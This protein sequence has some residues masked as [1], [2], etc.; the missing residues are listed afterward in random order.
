MPT[1]TLLVAG[2]DGKPVWGAVAS[3]GRMGNPPRTDAEGKLLW[4]WGPPRA[5]VPTPTVEVTVRAKGFAPAT[6]TLF[7]PGSGTETVTVALSK[8]QRLA[9]RVLQADGTPAVGVSVNVGNGSLPV[10]EVFPDAGQTW[11]I[12]YDD[13]E[14]SRGKIYAVASTGDDGTFSVEDLPDGPYHVAAAKAKR[15][16]SGGA[17][18]LRAVASAVPAGTSD[19]SLTLPVDD[20]PPTGRVEGRLVDAKT[21][22]PVANA[23]VGLQRGKETLAA[24]F[25]DPRMSLP[26][27]GGARIESDG[28][29]AFEDVPVG[30]CT[31][32]AGAAGYLTATGAALDVRVGQ[33]T[34]VPPIRLGV[35]ASIL[36]RLTGPPATEWKER[37]VSVQPVD[38]APDRSGA[39]GPVSQDGTYR[40]TGLTPG[41]Y[42]LVATTFYGLGDPARPPLIPPAT[43]V[44]VV[45]EADAEVRF[46]AALIAA[47]SLSLQPNDDRLPPPPFSPTKP[48]EEQKAFGAATRVTVR[49]PDGAILCDQ[50]GIARMFVSSGGFLTLPPGRYVAR[51]ELPGGEVREETVDLAAGALAEV[52]FAK[53]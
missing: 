18:P 39:E 15:V 20:S 38:P 6:A 46:D 5:G 23:T 11:P 14:A 44:I 45:P 30:P 35:G 8:G 22:G 32:S 53:K 40:V 4:I 51:L 13:P 36:G 34:T 37:Q 29:F 43:R 42:R 52:R 9:G 16:R 26:G 21:G 50:T 19:L 31:L 41:T 24:A 10:A 47:G 48:T 12:P 3:A 2:P 7:P 49:G 33:T 27:V 17:K 25:G 28:R 1:T